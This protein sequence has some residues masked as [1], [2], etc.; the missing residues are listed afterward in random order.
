MELAALFTNLDGD[1]KDSGTQTNAMDK[2]K[3]FMQTVIAM[4]AILHMEKQMARVFTLGSNGDIYDGEWKQ[5]VKS[6]NG[7]WKS[8]NNESYI[9]EWKDSKCEGYGV[10][11]WAMA[12]AMRANGKD[13]L[14]TATEGYNIPKWRCLRRWSLQWKNARE[15]AV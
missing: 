11:V 2:A 15:R 4:L 12:T 1:T 14:S 3:R 6:G 8:I 9:G 7:M 5:G 10:H 13:V